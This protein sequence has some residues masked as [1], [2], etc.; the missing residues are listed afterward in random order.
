MKH[1]TVTLRNRDNLKVSVGEDE[2]ITLGES[3]G[4][5]WGKDEN[6]SRKLTVS[7]ILSISSGLNR[8]FW[9][10][11]G[12]RTNFCSNTSFS[13]SVSVLSASELLIFSLQLRSKE[14]VDDFLRCLSRT[15][16]N[17]AQL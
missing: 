8:F 16:V 3:P 17:R 9:A 6:F 10:G 15:F 7:K 14:L 4:L 1:H 12:P 11:V 5:N 2:A 13:L